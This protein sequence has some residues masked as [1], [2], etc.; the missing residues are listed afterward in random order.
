M[1]YIRCLPRGWHVLQSSRLKTIQLRIPLSQKLQIYWKYSFTFER[2]IF[3]KT[4]SPLSFHISQPC[5]RDILA[6]EVIS[7]SERIYVG[8]TT[9]IP[10]IFHAKVR[11]I[12]TMTSTVYFNITKHLVI[13]WIRLFP[14]TNWWDV[15][16]SLLNSEERTI[17]KC[18]P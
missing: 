4:I 16:S 7:Q 17:E 1:A 11:R 2:C 18:L 12:T 14:L 13:E 10:P 6:T 15:N 9:N 8:Q 3:N 5:T